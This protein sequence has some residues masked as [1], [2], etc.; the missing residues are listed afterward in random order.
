MFLTFASSRTALTGPP[1]SNNS[2]VQPSGA[3]FKRILLQAPYCP[4][5]YMRYCTIF[6]DWKSI[7]VDLN[8]ALKS[9]LDCS[10][11]SPVTYQR[12]IRTSFNIAD[13]DD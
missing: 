6:D 13:N 12:Q 1:H 7:H 3:G 4:S 10:G 5:D 9:F 2:R 8:L 11:T